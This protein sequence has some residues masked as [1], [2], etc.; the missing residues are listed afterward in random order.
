MS[1]T[2][3]QT[4]RSNSNFTPTSRLHSGPDAQ[5]KP[6]QAKVPPGRTWLRFV[7]DPVRELFPMEIFLPEPQSAGRLCRTP[8]F[9]QEVGS[10]NVASIYSKGETI[11]GP[12]LAAGH[13]AAR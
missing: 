1:V 7:A 13:V 12:F 4:R 11:T 3:Q 2:E 5:K 9:K 10:G 8:S 6:K